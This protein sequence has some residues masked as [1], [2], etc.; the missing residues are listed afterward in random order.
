MQELQEFWEEHKFKLLLGGI[1]LVGLGIFAFFQVNL[2]KQSS[3]AT[4][5]S[6]SQNVS[7]TSSTLTSSSNTQTTSDYVYVDL[8]GAVKNPGVY[9]M[10]STARVTDV[11]KKAGGISEQ[12]D[13]NQ[14]NL[15]CKLTD[16]MLI[17]IP[18]IGEQP[19]IL[20]PAL[21]S[22]QTSQATNTQTIT[23][24]TTTDT[25]KINLNSATKEQLQQLNGIG[26]KK[27]D[28]I[29]Q[30]REDNGGFKTIEDL[31]NVSGIGD[32]TFESLKDSITV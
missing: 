19:D 32:K 31:K 1:V 20:S 10:A 25:N 29:I 27:A 13:I 12:A 3:Q 2:Q 17:Y 16:Q 4:A 8:K 9:K 5:L 21:I 18:Q 28:L 6:S 15:A 24:S 23:D 11:I 7:V 14:V 26:D 22:Q 30:Y